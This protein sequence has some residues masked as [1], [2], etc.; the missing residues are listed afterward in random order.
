MLVAVSCQ[1][2]QTICSANAPARLIASDNTDVLV[3]DISTDTRTLS[4]GETFVAL[5]GEHFDGNDYATLAVKRG[6]NAIVVEREIADI[7]VPQIVVQDTRLALRDLA[8]FQ[9]QHFAG[10]VIAITGSNGK[11]TTKEMIKSIFTIGHEVTATKGN[12]NNDLGVPFTVFDWTENDSVAIVEMGA[13]HVGEIG[14][15]SD[16]VSPDVAVITNV[17]EAHI[18]GFG[19]LAAIAEAKSEIYEG[20]FARHGIAVVNVDDAF[21][22]QWLEKTQDLRQLCFARQAPSTT[23]TRQPNVCVSKADES[24]YCQIGFDSGEVIE[25]QLPVRGLHNID[26]ALAAASVAYALNVDADVIAQGLATFEPVAGRLNTQ[27]FSRADKGKDTDENN[28]VTLIDDTYNANPASLQAAVSVMQSLAARKTTRVLVLG[29]L[30]EL[31]DSAADVH[32]ELGVSLANRVDAVF[33]VGTLTTFFAHGAMLTNSSAHVQHFSE[34]SELLSVLHDFL[35]TL[36]T[37]VVVLVK[38][39]RRAKMERVVAALTQTYSGS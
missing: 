8:K 21:S 10:K 13:N 32:H 30:G 25:V 2:L 31:G 33:C 28:A 14:Y 16:M 22:E 18:E 35:E 36:T 19:S 27:T 29:E 15:L 9:R 37:P 12:L 34:Q 38:G 6:A 5:S 24:G 7:S 26:N 39:S 20:L 4:V 11:T 17:S 1:Q 3:K 23:R